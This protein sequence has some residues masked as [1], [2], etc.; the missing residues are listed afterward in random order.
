MA[1][2]RPE[3]STSEV[4]YLHLEIGRRDSSGV[5]LAQGWVM[6]TSQDVAGEVGGAVT[7]G[8]FSETSAI[9]SI[10]A[11]PTAALAHPQGQFPATRYPAA[12]VALLNATLLRGTTWPVV[13]VTL[14]CFRRVSC[15]TSVGLDA[16]VMA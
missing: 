13:D 5:G 4:C 9:D 6:R 15:S 10:V 8:S 16:A 2:D 11:T 3:G 14:E 1:S 12:S 7:D